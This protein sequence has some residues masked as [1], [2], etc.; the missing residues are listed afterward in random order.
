MSQDIATSTLPFFLGSLVKYAKD[1]PSAWLLCER[2]ED[3]QYLPEMIKGTWNI[4]GHPNSSHFTP[5][6]VYGFFAT[7]EEA[8][9]AW[10]VAGASWQTNALLLAKLRR[11]LAQGEVEQRQAAI[12][13]AQELATLIETVRGEDIDATIK[14]VD[15]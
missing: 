6:F 11:Q 15:V 13:I 8:A 10:A 1:G 14:L 9:R 2:A 4:E 7:R 5:E 12:A 3:Q